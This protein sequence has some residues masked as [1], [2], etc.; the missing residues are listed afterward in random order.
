MG[1]ELI[2]YENGKE[3]KRY[4]ASVMPTLKFV[5]TNTTFGRDKEY[6]LKVNYARSQETGEKDKSKVTGAQLN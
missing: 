2:L 3:V 5:L 1:S 4:N 6:E